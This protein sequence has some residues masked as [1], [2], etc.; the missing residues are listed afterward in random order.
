MNSTKVINKALPVEFRTAATRQWL[1]KTD[2]LTGTN[3]MET[4]WQ[5]RGYLFDQEICRSDWGVI[6]TS[7]RAAIKAAEIDLRDRIK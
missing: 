7:E 3:L 1:G 5:A 4:T 6:Y 2:P